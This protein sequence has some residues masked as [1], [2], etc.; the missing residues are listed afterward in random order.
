M[1]SEQELRLKARRMA[2]EKVDFY[3]HLLFYIAINGGPITVW[4]LSGGGFPWFIFVLMFWGIGLAAHGIRA[5]VS[6]GYT[7][8]LAE[9]EYQRLRGQR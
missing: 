6:Q 9:R 8:I 7:D 5:F 2:E 1:E 3:V 4:W